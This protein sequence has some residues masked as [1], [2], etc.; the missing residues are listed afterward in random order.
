MQYNIKKN[1]CLCTPTTRQC[2]PSKHDIQSNRVRHTNTVKCNKIS[3]DFEKE[4]PQKTSSR[5]LIGPKTRQC[6]R[7]RFYVCRWNSHPCIY[8]SYVS[9]G[10]HCCLA[11]RRQIVCW[12]LM[13]RP[14]LVMQLD[15]RS[16]VEMRREDEA[17]THHVQGGMMRCWTNDGQ[18]GLRSSA[19]KKKMKM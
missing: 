16:E 8:Y 17:N 19:L 10:A 12:C 6:S 15:G 3:K 9:I 5:V 14:V 18:G 11:H 1:Y 13:E 2:T 4:H 7:T